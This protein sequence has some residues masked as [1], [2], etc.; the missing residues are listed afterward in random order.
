MFRNA[1]SISNLESH[2]DSFVVFVAKFTSEGDTN[3]QSGLQ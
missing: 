1:L 3:R 2:Q